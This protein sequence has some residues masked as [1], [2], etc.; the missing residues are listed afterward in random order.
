VPPHW[1]SDVARPGCAVID[2]HPVLQIRE[3]GSDGPPTQILAVAVGRYGRAL[4]AAA[5]PPG[6]GR[7]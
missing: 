7:A 2:G 3:R 4:V 1:L 6:G 5:D